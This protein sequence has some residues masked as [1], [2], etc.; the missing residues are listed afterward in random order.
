MSELEHHCLLF[1]HFLIYL[2]TAKDNGGKY[3]RNPYIEPLAEMG[4]KARDYC[5]EKLNES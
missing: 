5:Q 1:E 4:A 3:Y 2:M